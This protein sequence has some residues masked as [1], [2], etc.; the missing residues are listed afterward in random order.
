[1]KEKLARLIA[2]LDL[3]RGGLQ[4]S[5]AE[6][7]AALVARL[8]APGQPVWLDGDFLGA[9]A[10][11]TGERFGYDLEA[12][13][14][15]WAPRRTG[16]QQGNRAFSIRSRLDIPCPGPYTGAVTG[17]WA[18]VLAFCSVGL[19]LPFSATAEHEVFY[20]Y[21]VVGYVKDVKGAPLPG[22]S[23][24]LIREKTGFSYPAQTDAQGFFIV[25]ARLGDES[26][27]ERLTVKAGSLATTITA[28]F[29]PTNHTADR[30]TRLDFLGRK[31]VERSDWF[32]TTLKR[33]LAQ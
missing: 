31:S 19:A 16:S 26:V 15:W 27:G 1:V 12:W 11:L 21:V 6:T 20:R 3:L 18:R 8:G 2:A 30:G 7:L 22:I 23:V 32:A 29:D 5:D 17:K 33:F 25:V 9:L 14:M 4:R 13:R 24:E 10:V 28:R